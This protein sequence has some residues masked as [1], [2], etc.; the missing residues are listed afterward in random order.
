L[1]PGGLGQSITIHKNW[2]RAAWSLAIILFMVPISALLVYLGLHSGRQEISWSLVLFGLL[3]LATFGGSA[4][5]VVNTMRA[6]WRLELTP[7]FLSMY[8]P[9][10]DLRVPWE[11]LA[12]IGVAEA[13]RRQSCAL[14]FEDVAQVVG[15]ATFHSGPRRVDAVT[16]K[17]T[18]QKR[19]EENLD[20]MGYH[21][22]IPGR[23]LE[24]DAEALAE[25]LSRAR[26]G[27]LWSEGK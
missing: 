3:G 7:G 8:T 25:L 10:Y 24:M 13:N 17:T 16:D 6:P 5:L 23:I 1:K 15:G 18:M 21:L 9:R 22:A 4:V 2:K 12:S 14:V 27:E 26:T 20:I 19:M 11:K